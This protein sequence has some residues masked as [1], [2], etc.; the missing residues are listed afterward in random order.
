MSSSGRP[1][2]W[3]A[4]L[5]GLKA[6]WECFYFLLVLL[7]LSLQVTSFISSPSIT[8]TSHAPTATLASLE[9]F[10]VFRLAYLI[11]PIYLIPTLYLLFS[12]NRHPWSRAYFDLLGCY[13]LVRLLI[14]LAS[15]NLL[16]FSESGAK[17]L[18]LTQLMLF[19]PFLLIVW[20]WIYWRVDQLAPKPSKP[21]FR[22]EH[23]GEAPRPIDYFIASFSSIFSASINGVNGNYARSRILILLHGLMIYDVMGLTLSKVVALFAA[24]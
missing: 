14:Q 5:E 13:V 10:I 22:L 7:L 15:L 4:A 21:F 19:I 1:N 17:T 24:D 2:A 8:N 20:G 6:K 16:V 3:R 23:D 18:L 12:R 11:T 9:S